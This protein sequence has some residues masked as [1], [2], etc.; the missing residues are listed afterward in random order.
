MNE[1]IY[2]NGLRHE[3][4]NTCNEFDE[5]FNDDLADFCKNHYADSS[6]FTKLKEI[7]SDMKV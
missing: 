2:D 1:F 3:R 5:C 6:D 4:V 7:I